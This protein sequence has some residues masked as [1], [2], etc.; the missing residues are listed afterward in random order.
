MPFDNDKIDQIRKNKLAKEVAERE[1]ATKRIA[2]QTKKLEELKQKEF[3]YI[4]GIS[5][6]FIAKFTE[7]LE[8]STEWQELFQQKLEE[9]A[10][11]DDSFTFNLT[12]HHSYYSEAFVDEFDKNTGEIIDSHEE[13]I[14]IRIAIKSDFI[15]FELP[16]E[17]KGIFFTYNECRY[18]LEDCV[19]IFIN[20]LKQN[21]LKYKCSDFTGVIGAGKWSTDIDNFSWET[22]Q[23][24]TNKIIINF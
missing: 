8:S 23:K 4:R 5:E 15:S 18:I 24:L 20:T 11:R 6:S 16:G 12:L 19:Q 17:D 3:M 13:S 1:A 14:S 2:E 9:A 7:L 22:I 10:E 21:G